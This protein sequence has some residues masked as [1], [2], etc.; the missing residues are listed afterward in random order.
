M[1]AS[2]KPYITC[3]LLLSL[4]LIANINLHAQRNAKFG[5]VSLA[6]VRMKQYEKDT[7]AIAV[8][9][10]DKGHFKSADRKFHRHQRIKVLKS[11]GTSYGNIVLNV[12]FKS[13]FRAF[14]FN[15]KDGEMVR[16]KIEPSSVY[17]EEIFQGYYVY[18]LFLPNVKIGSVIDLE[19]SH[20]GI[21]FEWHFQELIPVIHS[22]LILEP[23]RYYAYNKSFKGF[24]E[25]KQLKPHHWLATDV[26]AF[27]PE[28]FLN[29]YSNYITKFELNYYRDSWENVNSILWESGGF[30]GVLRGCS[31]LNDKAKEIKQ[32][33]LTVEEKVAEAYRY[34]QE[35]IKWNKSYGIFSS[36]S[37][38]ENFKKNHSGT[39]SD[40]NLMLVSLL[41]KAD[42]TTY[43]VVL[44]TRENGFL[45]PLIP[46]IR[47][48]NYVVAYVEH[49][50]TQILLDAASEKL[51]PGVLPTKCLSGHGWVVLDEN[52]G[53]WIDLISEKP[54]QDIRLIDIK[55][56]NQG[57]HTASISLSRTQYNYLNWLNKF[58]SVSD[59]S[60]YAQLVEGS[61]HK[62]D[63]N[64]YTLLKNDL[65]TLTSSEKF[66]VNI[67]NQIDDLGNS[68]VLNPYLMSELFE[69]P[70]KAEKR[71]YPVDLNYTKKNKT[72]ISIELPK[73]F[74]ISQLPESI[75]MTTPDLGASFVFRVMK[76]GQKIQIQYELNI[77][78]T[79]FTEDEYPA[80][81][82][83]HSAIIDKLSEALQIEK[84]T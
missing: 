31:F 68:I 67:D 45:N 81:R 59:E 24:E 25:V 53:K 33:E 18:K 5:K 52:G 28:P 46:S 74:I 14:V 69:N 34:I 32:S 58:E 1:I 13:L 16:E 49:D 62:L 15:M 41:Q 29:H 22:E 30:G 55:L 50:N 40:I 66:D 76:S 47:K 6:D 12:P 37:Y 77:L 35:N 83:F 8:V 42:I 26:P 21:P 71:K 60:K 78:K 64:D 7:N 65:G 2:F 11:A 44:S 48:F 57:L 82:N 72:I 75:S 17:E 73:E 63:I 80:L 9:L 39:V 61:Q 38:R 54:S 84:K 56:D 27:S 70:F 10:Y 4:S 51:K 79:I 3:Y 20:P 19:Y 23:T 43:P 36:I